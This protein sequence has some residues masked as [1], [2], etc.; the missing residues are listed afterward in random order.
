M[1]R[2]IMDG[3]TVAVSETMMQAMRAVPKIACRYFDIR[4]EQVLD[5]NKGILYDPKRD[6]ASSIISHNGE[7][8][9]VVILP[10]PVV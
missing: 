4:N 9:H 7:D 1:Y 8:L 6:M 3:D 5:Y 10:I 2:I